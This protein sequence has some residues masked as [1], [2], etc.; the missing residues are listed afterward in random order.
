MSDN[1]ILKPRA[2]LILQLGDQLIKNESI[3]LLELVKNAYDAG[4][5]IVDIHMQKLT[6]PEHGE[7][8]I[9]DDG[10]G[11]DTDIVQ[12]VWLEPGSDYKSQ[13]LEK[14]VARKHRPSR[15]P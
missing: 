15:L 11:M 5:T 3:A 4:A 1:L 12:N 7:I 10:I 9:R 6:D 8:T 2:R 13:L 14:L